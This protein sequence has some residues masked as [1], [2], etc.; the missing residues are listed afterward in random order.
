MLP[1]FNER[2]GP[3]TRQ[4][5]AIGVSAENFE[6]IKRRSEDAPGLCSLQGR[7]KS[8][9]FRDRDVP[10][11]ISRLDP[12]GSRPRNADLRLLPDLFARRMVSEEPGSGASARAD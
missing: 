6:K 11:G 12:G 5:A 2:M 8:D 1:G 9:G 3:R 10:N 7:P 4:S